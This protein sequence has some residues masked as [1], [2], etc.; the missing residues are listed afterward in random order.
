M[1]KR[2][3]GLTEAAEFLSS[4]HKQQIQPSDVMEMA[5]R[6]EIHLYTWGEGTLAIFK[7]NGDSVRFVRPIGGFRGY[8][9]IPSHIV[10]PIAQS[11]QFWQIFLADDICGERRSEI[12]FVIH[13]DYVGIVES[14]GDPDDMGVVD[15]LAYTAFGPF[16]PRAFTPT[17]DEMVVPAADLLALSPAKTTPHSKSCTPSVGGHVSK[18]NDNAG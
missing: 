16:K 9:L 2:Y 17:I 13:P 12:P 3:Y 10:S 7:D 5:A 1:L 8:I 18:R 11:C 6:G 4:E 15:L 14:R